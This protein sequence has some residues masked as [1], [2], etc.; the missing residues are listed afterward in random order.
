[1]QYE[2]K[3]KRTNSA[4]EMFIDSDLLV[5]CWCK[6]SFSLTENT[7]AHAERGQLANKEDMR[8]HT[9]F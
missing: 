5:A 2:P 4:S 6:S 9:D 3:D 7:V 1:M 8:A